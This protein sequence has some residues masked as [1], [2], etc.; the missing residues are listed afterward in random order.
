MVISTDNV[1]EANRNAIRQSNSYC[2]Q[3][4][5]KAY[6]LTESKKYTGD[7]D[8]STYNAGKRISKAAQVFSGG[9]FVSADSRKEQKTAQ[10][11]GLGGVAIDDAF[12][13]GYTVEM[14]FKC[15]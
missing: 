5:K 13:N 15:R 11:V 3:Y 14:K 1:D 6:F 4:E 9:V 12:G 10:K 2:E 8:E 7:M